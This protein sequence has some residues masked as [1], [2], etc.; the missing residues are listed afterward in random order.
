M[1]SSV[2]RTKDQMVR[3]KTLVGSSV[4]RTKDLWFCLCLLLLVL[5][6]NLVVSQLLELVDEL[7]VGKA[8][9]VCEL[10]VA[11][12]LLGSG[13]DLLGRWF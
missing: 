12:D 9:V 7:V 11:N 5:C 13:Q 3:R 4:T 6:E 8:N 2:T 10:G 1:G